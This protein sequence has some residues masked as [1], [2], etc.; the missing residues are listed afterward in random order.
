VTTLSPMTAA[1]YEAWRGES[2]PDYA[3][4]KRVGTSR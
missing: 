3:L 4:F 1:E 2:I